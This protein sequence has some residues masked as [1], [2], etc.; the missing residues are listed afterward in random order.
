G[1]S[2]GNAGSVGIPGS[3]VLNNAAALGIGA[4]ERIPGFERIADSE[5]DVAAEFTNRDLAHR[6]AGTAARQAGV[7]EI[8]RGDRGEAQAILDQTLREDHV[9][10]V[11]KAGG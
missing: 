8:G 6:N 4:A 11:A 1:V 3:E 2:G 7:N 9:T 10:G 5:G